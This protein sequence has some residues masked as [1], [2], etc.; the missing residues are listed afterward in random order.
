MTVE[1]TTNESKVL[2]EAPYSAEFV[3]GARRLAGKWSKPNWVFPLT[4]EARVRALCATVYGYDGGPVETVTLRL[5]A[6]DR[7]TSDRSGVRIA[8]RT[9][10]VAF[11]R[12]SGA[13]LG[14]GVVQIAGRCNSGGSRKN[15]YTEIDAGS[16]FEL[17]GVPRPMAQ[18]AIDDAKRGW[19]F[20]ILDT[21]V[22]DREELE[23]ERARLVARLAEID[24]TL[25]TG[26]S[27]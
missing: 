4:Q 12:D 1:I 7:V 26:D 16:I 24:A 18:K 19:T 10:A 11:E 3:S 6:N 21:A 8:G 5:T 15:W 25:H 27:A 13:R 23:V 2:V 17:E 22:P 20:E 14:E 9:I